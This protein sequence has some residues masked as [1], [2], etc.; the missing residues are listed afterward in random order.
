MKKASYSINQDREGSF[1][2]KATS[3]SQGKDSLNPTIAFFTG[4]SE[5]RLAPLHTK[6]QQTFRMVVRRSHPL[7]LKEKPQMFQLSFEATRELACVVVTIPI[8]GDKLDEPGIEHPPFAHLGR[9]IGHVA[10]SAQLRQCICSKTEYCLIFTFRE[11][12][13][14]P[15]QMGQAR[16]SQADPFLVDSVTVS[17]QNARPVLDQLFKGLFRS[18]GMDH[19]ISDQRVAH[20]PKPAQIAVLAPGGFINMVHGSA[21]G[22]DA[23][24]LVMGIYGRGYA[25]DYLLDRAET[26]VDSKHRCAKILDNSSTVGLSPGHLRDHRRKTGAETRTIL[27]GDQGFVQ[28]S[29]AR[30]VSPE[31]MDVGDSHLHLGELDHLVR[32]VL[33]LIWIMAVAAQT[34]HGMN[35]S[36]FRGCQKRLAMA[37]VP[38]LRARLAITFLGFLLGNW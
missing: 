3:L 37:F 17:H 34:R 15:D 19:E 35:L 23:D 16:L 31:Q 32:I 6:P 12:S 38:L 25:V 8:G 21:P 9:S 22:R 5:A 24:R 11:P 29:T 4:R 14:V 26:D 10:Q 7:L 33:L 28:L 18:S 2:L 13:G 20:Y 1:P 27:F 36:D 30:A